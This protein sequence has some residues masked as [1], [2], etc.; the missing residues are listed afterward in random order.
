MMRITAKSSDFK[1]LFKDNKSSDFRIEVLRQTN[2]V[3]N[4]QVALT[5]LIVP[6]IEEDKTCYIL[7]SICCYSQCGEVYRRVLRVV[8]LYA[9]KRAQQVFLEPLERYDLNQRT[10]QEIRFTFKDEK[11]N[12]IAFENG[13]ET[14]VGIE[15][16]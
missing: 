2:F 9:G 14:F 15:I 4:A 8:E 6:P 13:Y 16:K 11:D 12:F 7:C 3:P 5:H 10:F 1:K